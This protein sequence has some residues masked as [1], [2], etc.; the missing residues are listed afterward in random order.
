M[1]DF[2]SQLNGKVTTAR[3]STE[4]SNNN[5]NVNNKNKQNKTK[6]S[7]IHMTIIMN[8]T[9]ASESYV[10]IQLYA[11]STTLSSCTNHSVSLVKWLK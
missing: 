7:T 10:Y 5:K 4:N 6:P 11:M 2:L 3:E 9:L 1:Q 8:S